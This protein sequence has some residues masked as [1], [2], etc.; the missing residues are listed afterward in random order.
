MFKKI[1]GR[2]FDVIEVRGFEFAMGRQC[3]DMRCLNL[4]EVSQE[5]G[6]SIIK[7]ALEA[8]VRELPGRGG[9]RIEAFDSQDVC[10]EAWLKEEG[11]KTY[12]V[13]IDGEV[14]A[15]ED[16]TPL[17]ELIVSLIGEMVEE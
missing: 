3:P 7:E 2:G 13:S 14:V 4:G 8:F 17:N 12:N 16:A 9:W 5:E 1:N 6:I 15:T 11:D 10:Y